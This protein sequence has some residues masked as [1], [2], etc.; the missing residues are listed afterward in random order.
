MG[1]ECGIDN[2]PPRLQFPE[3]KLGFEPGSMRKRWDLTSPGS[4]TSGLSFAFICVQ[5]MS[6]LTYFSIAV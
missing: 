4:Q 6:E 3:Q 2:I 5:Y 1:L